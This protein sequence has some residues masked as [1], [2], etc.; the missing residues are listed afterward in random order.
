MER[1]ADLL[2]FLLESDV[3]DAN[4]FA[5]LPLSSPLSLHIPS[6]PSLRP[7]SVGSIFAAP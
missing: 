5:S 6:R 4:S 7:R 3:R 1:L 2:D